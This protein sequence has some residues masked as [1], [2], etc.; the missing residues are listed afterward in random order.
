[1][2][3]VH[4]DNSYYFENLIAIEWLNPFLLINFDFLTYMLLNFSRLY[5]S[6]VSVQTDLC[7]KSVKMRLAISSGRFHHAMEYLIQCVF[8]PRKPG[9][10][11]MGHSTRCDAAKLCLF[12]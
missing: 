8:N 5:R 11:F 4:I 7:P 12:T 9:V 10:L 6:S 1:M 3:H 2:L